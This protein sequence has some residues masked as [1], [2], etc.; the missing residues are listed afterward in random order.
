MNKVSLFEISK[1]HYELIDLIETG[2]NE[3]GKID[4][5]VEA[6]LVINK[7][8]Y[9]E[10]VIDYVAV[11]NHKK[12][13]LEKAKQAKAQ[14]A[15]FESRAKRVIDQLEQ[16]LLDAAD[17]FGPVEAGFY[18]VGI[19]KSEE[20]IIEDLAKIPEEY[21]DRKE[22]VSPDKT[23]IKKAIKAGTEVPGAWVKNKK[24]LSIK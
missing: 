16:R 4:E 21:L 6:A 1:E 8:Q 23:A 20:T 15:A 11:I 9:V 10:K 17:V 18:K 14:I 24:N 13:D 22:V 19:R 2:T 5:F 7:E 3:E 12:M